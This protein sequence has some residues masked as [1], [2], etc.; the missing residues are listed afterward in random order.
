MRRAASAFR[1]L[2]A[3]ARQRSSSPASVKSVVTMP[4]ISSSVWTG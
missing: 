3:D 4:V 1:R 2:A